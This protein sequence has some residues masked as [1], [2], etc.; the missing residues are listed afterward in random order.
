MSEYSDKIAQR[1]T[2]N[3][4]RPTPNAQRPTPI[5]AQNQ[6]ETIH[7]ALAVYDPSGTYSQHAGVVMTS[8]FENTKSKVT[9]H[10]L[11]DDTL[12]QDN[13]QKFI[14]TAEKYSQGL[15]L[16]D[17]TGYRE[18]IDRKVADRFRDGYT[19]GALFRLAIQDII[20]L[21]KVIYLDCDIVVNMDIRELWDVDLEGKYLAGGLDEAV[22]GQNNLSYEGIKCWLNGCK[23]SEYINSGVMLM[24]LEAIREL[25][26]FFT[27]AAQWLM[28]HLYSAPYADQEAYNALFPGQIKLLDRKYNR[29]KDFHGQDISGT[30]IHNIW[31]KPWRVL[32]GD[33]NCILYWDM[34]LRSA[35]GENVSPIDLVRRLAEIAE[36]S[37]SQIHTSSRQC[38]KSVKYSILQKLKIYSLRRTASMVVR[39]FIACLKRKNKA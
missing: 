13:R 27:T 30:I 5:H 25:G 9:V 36:L 16:H 11:H 4:Q 7:V 10:I 37:S 28:S 3:A 21:A 38:L 15:E 33:E 26:D 31:T 2:P 20:P 18:R 19:I 8:I 34:F 32:S 29:H 39:H 12:T 6:D 22:S 35:W 24:D 1:P 23:V 14:R 17:V